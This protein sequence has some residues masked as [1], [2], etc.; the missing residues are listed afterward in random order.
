MLSNFQT[1][2]SGDAH[3]KSRK[4]RITVVTETYPPEING[5]AVTVAR[6]VKG[7]LEGGHHVQLVRPRQHSREVARAGD[8]FSELLAIGLA[9]PRYPDLKFGLPMARKLVRAWKLHRPDVVHIATEGPLGASASKAAKRMGIPVVSEFRTNF[10]AYSSHYGIGFLHNFIL[11]YL[12]RFHNRTARTL[13]PTAA[14]GRELV[15]QGFERVHVVARG[16]DVGL[17]DPA[18]RDEGLRASW[19]AGPETLVAAAV[20]RVAAEKNLGLMSRAFA[21]MKS[22]RPDTK[23]VMVGDGPARAS[24]EESTPDTLFAGKRFGEDLATHYASAD[25]LLFPSKTETFGNATLEAMASGLAV[26]AFDYGAAGEFVVTGKNGW[27]VPFDDEAEY[28]RAAATAAGDLVSVRQ[29]GVQARRDAQG[30]GWD[31]ILAQIEMHYAGAMDSGPS[32]P[33]AESGAEE[34]PASLINLAVPIEES[35]PAFCRNE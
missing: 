33:A 11:G 3:R 8:E 5:V 16:V 34:E 31:K 2:D 1:A 17:F 26:L 21:R 27:A 35:G 19:G 7:L 24:F 18:R 32:W 10:H 28:L 9:I 30:L 20:G 13:V 6:V 14:L 15:Q 4:L 12:R 23:L 22:I 25:M 29:L